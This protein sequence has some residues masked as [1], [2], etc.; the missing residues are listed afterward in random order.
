MN[1]I[2][3]LENLREEFLANANRCHAKAAV[4]EAATTLVDDEIAAIKGED[5]VVR[6]EYEPI[7]PIPFEG[8]VQGFS[9]T[10]PVPSGT[11][12]LEY[13]FGVGDVIQLNGRDWKVEGLT[14][15][16]Y[17]LR[18]ISD[19]LP[20]ESRVP[21]TSPVEFVDSEAT[22]IRRAGEV[23]KKEDPLKVGDKV[24][25]CEHTALEPSFYPGTIEYF[26]EQTEQAGVRGADGRLIL[27]S[28][29]NLRR[30]PPPAPEKPARPEFKIGQT[31][32]THFGNA[33]T[34]KDIRPETALID[35]EDGYWFVWN[36]GCPI[37]QWMLL[38][39]APAKPERP[40]YKAGQVW[41]GQRGDMLTLNAE[42]PVVPGWYWT[43]SKGAKGFDCTS[44]MDDHWTFVSDAP[45][46]A[47]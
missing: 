42:C 41:R 25:E 37:H 2:K 44:Y 28:R 11:V 13:K 14:P 19:A 21:I 5:D 39:D 38:V 22:L 20:G 43:N 26:I 29:K 33:I 12:A 36:D 17:V 6:A 27:R 45:E 18:C 46:A 24:G 8:P 3:R 9:K 10:S 4:W 15:T 1:A 16:H 47:P 35:E 32:R 30:V 7:P 31:W 23:E 40:A 34:I